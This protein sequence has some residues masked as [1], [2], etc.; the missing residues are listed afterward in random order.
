MYASLYIATFILIYFIPY[1]Y[2]FMFRTQ[3]D[4]VK[5]FV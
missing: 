5:I 4:G 2:Y 1:F 3:N